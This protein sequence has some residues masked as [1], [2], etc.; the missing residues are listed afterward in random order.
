MIVRWFNPTAWLSVVLA[1]HE[2]KKRLDSGDS[3]TPSG[4]TPAVRIAI[5]EDHELVGSADLRF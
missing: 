2:E 3:T 5:V 4:D 1:V